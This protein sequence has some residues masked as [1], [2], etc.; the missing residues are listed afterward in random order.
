[1]SVWNAFDSDA[2]SLQSLTAAINKAAYQPDIIASLGLFEEQGIPDTTAVLEEQDGVLSLVSVAPR[3]GVGQPVM[4]GGRTARA[5]KIPHLPERATIMADEVQGV[6][7][8]GSESGASSVEIKRNERLAIMRANL[9]YTLESHRLAA[10]QGNFIDANGASV[11]LA[12]TFGVVA[13]TPVSFALGTD[14]TKILGKCADVLGGIEDGLGGSPF[15]GV[16][17]LCG[18]TFWSSLIDHPKVKDAVVGWQAAQTLRND[19]RLA[20]TYGGLN[21]VRYRGTS[22]VKVADGE[23]WAVPTGVAGLA[24]TRFAPA[25][26]IETVNT[27]GLPFYAKAAADPMGKGVEIE[28]QSNPLNLITRPAAIVKLTAT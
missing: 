21:F 15:T 25:N 23:A 1:M 16:T 9:E 13:A 10:I 19:A 5:F 27:I 6:R 28:A 22:A 8:F 11:S 14:T 17:V 18:K 4:D 2:F 3:N 24:I 12:T 7:A 20:L 26:Y